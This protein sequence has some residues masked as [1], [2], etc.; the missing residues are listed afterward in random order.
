M[1]FFL[2]HFKRRQTIAE[3]YWSVSNVGEKLKVK[4]MHTES[5]SGRASAFLS[6][7]KLVKRKMQQQPLKS[8]ANEIA[9]NWS[10]S[11]KQTNKQCLER[12][13]HADDDDA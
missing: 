3:L 6:K 13:L 8:D 7:T 12:N 9:E 11:K 2:C 1:W 4:L 10:W 5:H